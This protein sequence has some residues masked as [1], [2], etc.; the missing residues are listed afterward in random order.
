MGQV[1][2]LLWGPA[3][4][5]SRQVRTK[6]GLCAGKRF[7]FED[8]RRIEAFLGIPFARPPV[9]ELRFRVSTEGILNSKN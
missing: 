8:G 6:Q 2:S 3:W 7:Q 1:G 4:E 9:G 5:P